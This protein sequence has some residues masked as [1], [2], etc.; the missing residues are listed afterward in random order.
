[1]AGKAAKGRAGDAAPAAGQ[2][3]KAVDSKL[4]WDPH[5]T[6]PDRGLATNA[7]RKA[8]PAG[9]FI[10]RLTQE[11]S[12]DDR[13]IDPFD[14]VCDCESCC[15]EKPRRCGD[16][17]EGQ[18]DHPV[19]DFCR[20][21]VECEGSGCSND[22]RDHTGCYGEQYRLVCCLCSARKAFFEAGPPVA[23]ALCESCRKRYSDPPW[24]AKL[25]EEAAANKKSPSEKAMAVKKTA[26][27]KASAKR[28][29]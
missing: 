17:R 6:G 25:K 13:E 16:D 11:E 12:D 14:P 24:L 5:Y 15:N 10:L 22:K 3:R 18:N 26:P 21:R 23:E 8:A 20:V 28:K 19:G 9:S 1:M 4:G 27:Q 7:A 2:Y 29:D